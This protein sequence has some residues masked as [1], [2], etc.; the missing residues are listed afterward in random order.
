MRKINWCLIFGFILLGAQFAFSAITAKEI[1]K[2]V[3]STYQEIKTISIEFQQ[4]FK[5]RLAGDSHTL[6]GK[7]FIKDN[8]K[9]RIEM[10]D[11][12][13]V[14]NGKIAWNYS[15]TNKQVI[16][17]NIKQADTNQLPSNLLLKYSEEYQISLLG[18]ELV[19]GIAC[20]LLELK[21]KTGDDYYQQMKIWISKKDW[22]TR[23]IEQLDINQNTNTYLI[24]SITTNQPLDENLFVFATPA[25]VEEVDLRSH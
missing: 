4:N 9:Y 12:T 20:Y 15:R 16:I 14:T 7:L 6:N 24:T 22:F 13:V 1:V 5:W 3:K 25:G 2:K 23:K 17:E 19:N 21:T 11:N 8:L 10:P 18:E